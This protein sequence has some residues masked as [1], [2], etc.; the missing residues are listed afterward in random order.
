MENKENEKKQKECNFDAPHLETLYCT[1]CEKEFDDCD[2][3]FNCS[4]EKW[5]GFGSK[6]DLTIFKAHLC[7]TCF[8]KVLDTILPMFKKSPLT[9]YDLVNKDGKLI[10]VPVKNEDL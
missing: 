1:M 6:Y 3:D 4:I 8:D 10:A 2:Y 9:E 5:I 7:C